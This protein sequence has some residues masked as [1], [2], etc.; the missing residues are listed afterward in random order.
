MYPK[1]LPTYQTPILSPDIALFC[2]SLLC[3]FLSC[4]Y[5]NIDKS[6]DKSEFENIIVNLRRIRAWR[7]KVGYKE[8]NCLKYGMMNNYMSYRVW[9]YSGV[10]ANNLDSQ[11]GVECGNFSIL[12]QSA[13]VVQLII[14]VKIFFSTRSPILES[15][16][17]CAS[18]G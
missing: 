7:F 12:I 6:Y 4:L 10:T 11:Y 2:E 17:V 1:S 15:L 8:H 16:A 13:T 3:L 14:Y 5:S 9:Q 18:Y